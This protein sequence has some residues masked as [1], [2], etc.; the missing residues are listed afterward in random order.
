MCALGGLLALKEFVQGAFE[1]GVLRVD[2]AEGAIGGERFVGQAEG[3]HFGFDADQAALE[4]V[5]LN[6]GVDQEGFDGTDG[7]EGLAVGGG[8]RFESREVFSGNDEGLGIEPVADGVETRDGLALGGARAGGFQG[9]EA[10]G[11]VL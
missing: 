3:E 8:E 4:P 9:V 10:V 7:A 6:D 2:G 5:G 11:L 1:L